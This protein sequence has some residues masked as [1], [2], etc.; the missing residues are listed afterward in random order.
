MYLSEGKTASV[1]QATQIKPVDQSAF[2][3]RQNLFYTVGNVISAA[4]IIEN[5]VKIP[6]ISKIKYNIVQQSPCRL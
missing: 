4:A 5:S 2:T 1:T 6:K 3:E